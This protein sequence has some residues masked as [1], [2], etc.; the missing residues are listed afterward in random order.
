MCACLSSLKM[1]LFPVGGLNWKS[2]RPIIWFVLHPHGGCPWTVPIGASEMD[3]G[4]FR[5]LSPICGHLTKSLWETISSSFLTGS[6]QQCIRAQGWAAGHLVP[7]WASL[8]L[9]W[10]FDSVGGGCGGG[11]TGGGCQGPLVYWTPDSLWL[12]DSFYYVLS[13]GE[14][15]E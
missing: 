8:W 7:C 6:R 14:I 4:V 3:I 1:L 11:G 2:A 9:R 15:K 10:A 5:F 12:F 13:L